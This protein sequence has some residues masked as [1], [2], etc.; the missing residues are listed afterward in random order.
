[1]AGVEVSVLHKPDLIGAPP[2]SPN[3]FSE[4]N[5]VIII[6]VIFGIIAADLKIGTPDL[7]AGG[8]FQIRQKACC[9]SLSQL[10]MRPRHAAKL[11]KAEQMLESFSFDMSGEVCATG[12]QK[13]WIGMTEC[14]P[15]EEE[16]VSRRDIFFAI[17]TN[18]VDFTGLV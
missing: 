12:G 8:D 17:F 1:M 5:L 4:W 7:A 13:I 9:H 3:C 6:I 2:R 16:Q 14:D 15:I 18:G 10:L 11:R